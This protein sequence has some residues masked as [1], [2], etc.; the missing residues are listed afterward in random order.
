MRGFLTP[1]LAILFSATSSNASVIY[2]SIDLTTSSND[3]FCS[4]CSTDPRWAGSPFTLLSPTRISTVDL[5]V[6]AESTHEPYLD[7]EI[8]ENNNSRTGFN[9]GRRYI[10]GSFAANSYTQIGPNNFLVNISVGTWDLPAGDYFIFFPGLADYKIS[11]FQTG[12]R[13]AVRVTPRTEFDNVWGLSTESANATVGFRLNTNGGHFGPGAFLSAEAIPE[14][15]NWALLIGGF[16]LLGATAR[17]VRHSR[18]AI[19][20]PANAGSQI[21]EEQTSPT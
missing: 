16:A 14:P 9:I 11:R 15:A 19:A 17:R 3:Y 4:P 20:S 7:V 8:Y 13:Q 12:D 2:Q 5:S 1:C 21:A 18:A 6:Y 10:K